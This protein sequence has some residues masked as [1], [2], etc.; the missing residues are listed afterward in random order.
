[1]ANKNK[2]YINTDKESIISFLEDKSLFMT[3]Y[4]KDHYDSEYLIIYKYLT[5]SDLLNRGKRNGSRESLDKNFLYYLSVDEMKNIERMQERAFESAKQSNIGVPAVFF[6]ALGV[7]QLQR[8]L[9]VQDEQHNHIKIN[10]YANVYLVNDTLKYFQFDY[11][12]K[13]LTA[14]GKHPEWLNENHD[15]DLSNGALTPLQIT[16]AIHG[17]GTSSDALFRELRYSM[18]KNDTLIL[19]I[20]RRNNGVK[21]LFVMLEKNPRFFTI[22]GESNI[23][24][25][26][27][28]IKERKRAEEI[29]KKKTIIDLDEEDKSRKQQEKWRELLAEEMMNF[30]TV[31]GEVFCPFTFITADFENVGTL[32]RAS[33]IKAF[34]ECSSSEAYDINNG[35]LLCANADALFDK[36]LITIDEDKNLMFSFLL[37]N[38]VKLK[39]NLLLTQP[40]FKLVLNDERMKYIKHHRDVFNQL[41]NKRK[42]R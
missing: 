26:N 32:F 11:T 3:E 9:G 5:H 8:R 14:L 6:N 13:A 25:E 17:I 37:D 2:T 10:D 42:M 41:E 29:L 15:L 35:L 33:H 30:T 16:H 24:W 34:K 19:L 36:H 23:K 31:D 28:S 22:I 39:S 27:Y 1:M 40:I 4:I 20:E 18:F 38:D 21:N 7:P 12:R